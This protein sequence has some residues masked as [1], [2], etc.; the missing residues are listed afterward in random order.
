MLSRCEHDCTPR[1]DAKVE[2]DSEAAEMRIAIL[3]TDLREEH[4]KYELPNPYF[5]PAIEAFLQG[6]AGLPEP[7]IHVISCAQQPMRSPQK[8]ADHIYFHSLHVPKIGWLRTFYQGCIRAVRRKLQEIQP[9]LVH[10][11][12]TERDCAICA[13]FSGFPNVVS[14]HGNV[15]RVAKSISASIGSFWWCAAL[16]ERFTMPR[17]GGVLCNSAYTESV[18]RIHARRTWRVP[19]AV[20]REFFETPISKKPTTAKPILL[21]VGV[22][23]PYKRQLELL[24]LARDLHR[25]GNVFELQFIGAAD[26]KS[27]YGALFLD[28]IAIAERNGFAR[29]LGTKSLRELIAALDSASALIHA[30]AEEAFGLVVAE[31]L[32]RNLKFFGTAVGGVSDI[33]SGVE[34]AEPFSPD[35]Q[36]AL[37]T[38]IANWLHAGCPQPRLAA[39]EMHSRYHPEVIAKRHLEIYREFLGNRS[40]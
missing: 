39:E 36:L 34:Y 20:R 35:D 12:G 2:V 15:G 38:A 11:H 14:I 17:T 6:L 37:R 7:D 32:S 3:A 30:P 28:Q 25:E 16:L 18:V 10:G 29:Y 13:I 23:S 27:R 9:N 33:V 8:I 40:N 31:G 4:R 21:S 19:N 24:E 22:V 26:R 5:H 1:W